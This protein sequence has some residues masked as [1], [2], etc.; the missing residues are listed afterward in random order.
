METNDDN[1]SGEDKNGAYE[2]LG[3]ELSIVQSAKTATDG[4]NRINS[5]TI[6]CDPSETSEVALLLVNMS[7]SVVGQDEEIVELGDDLKERLKSICSTVFETHTKHEESHRLKALDIAKVLA[8]F[9]IE[10]TS[11][12]L[13][14][15]EMFN[16]I[17]NSSR[18]SFSVNYGY[19]L[20]ASPLLLE[21]F[22]QIKT[23]YEESGVNRPDAS[24]KIFAEYV[25][26]ALCQIDNTLQSLDNYTLKKVHLAEKKT[27]ETIIY[28]LDPTPE[29][30]L[31]L[32]SD[33]V[34][35]KT[36]RD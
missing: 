29:N 36:V 10:E 30:T 31:V 19:H 27:D 9:L 22:K 8:A 34:D 35:L 18:D 25:C 6:G 15:I 33:H 24:L 3:C 12:P 20:K 1:S 21:A 5:G 23:L 14:T 4:E 2:T 13:Y 32:A 7:N 26:T 17:N 16:R 11:S 28:W